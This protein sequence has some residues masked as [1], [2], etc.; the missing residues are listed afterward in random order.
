MVPKV[1]EEY[2][3]RDKGT[4]ISQSHST[5][6]A[7][8]PGTE[9]RV[10][11]SLGPEMATVP[12]LNGTRDEASAALSKAGLTGNFT[13]EY[14]DSVAA[15]SV[16]RFDPAAGTQV[17]KGPSVNVVISKGPKPTEPPATQPPTAP[18][19]DPGGTPSGS[20]S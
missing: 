20:G 1:T 4:I 10:V 8:A 3:D 18:A 2:N 11:I 19:A 14:S 17:K 5:G 7:V 6:T 13:E 12:N 16:I 15:G 9:I